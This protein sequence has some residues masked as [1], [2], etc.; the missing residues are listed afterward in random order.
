MQSNKYIKQKFV[1]K[2]I[3]LLSNTSR[4]RKPLYDIVFFF[5]KL[6]KVHKKTIYL[7]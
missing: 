3:K 5:T 2:I 1:G 7:A 6:L 4:V